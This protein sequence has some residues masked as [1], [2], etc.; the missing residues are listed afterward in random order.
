[1]STMKESAEQGAMIE[2]YMVNHPTDVINHGGLRAC[3][4]VRKELDGVALSIFAKEEAYLAKLAQT[5]DHLTIGELKRLLAAEVSRKEAAGEEDHP[6]PIGIYNL[7]L[8]VE[9]AIQVRARYVTEVRVTDMLEE[10]IDTMRTFRDVHDPRRLPLYSKVYVKGWEGVR[11][12]LTR[13]LLTAILTGGYEV[14]AYYHG[15]TAPISLEIAKG[16]MTQDAK[17]WLRPVTVRSENENTIGYV[18]PFNQA[19][20]SQ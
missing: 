18:A 19:G 20:G 8:E 12:S 5:E 7:C 14:L 16:I 3:R 17:I 9:D 4:R 1:M 2:T 13:E 11:T 6:L 10:V 15:D